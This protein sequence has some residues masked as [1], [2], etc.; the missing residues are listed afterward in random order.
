MPREIEERKVT[1]EAAADRLVTLAEELRG[2]GSMDVSVENKT[3]SLS[4][5]ADVT[6]E[7]SVREKSTL[8]RGDREGITVKMDWKPE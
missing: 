2:E 5:P 1:R 7:V 3:I 6:M 4:P 8:F